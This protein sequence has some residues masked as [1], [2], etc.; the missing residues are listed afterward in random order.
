MNIYIIYFNVY[1]IKSFFVSIIYDV[2]SNMDKIIK[3]KYL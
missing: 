1:F 3:L 2:R